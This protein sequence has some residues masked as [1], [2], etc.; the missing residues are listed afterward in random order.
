MGTTENKFGVAFSGGGY[1]ATTYHIGTMRA[2]H[3]LRV[4][5]KID[6]L[7][8][9]SGGSIA[10]AY[11]TLH[12]KN[13]AYPEIE[14]GLLAGLRKNTVARAFLQPRC[15]LGAIYVLGMI[16]LIGFSFAFWH[17]LITSGILVAYILSIVFFQFTIFPISL[18][19]Q[20]AYSWLFFKNKKMGD[21]S[22]RP[23]LVMNATN[24]ETGKLWSFSKRKMDDA[25][26]TNLNP[27]ILFK[28]ENF[29]I[30]VAVS[31]SSC[32]PFAFNPVRIGKKYFVNK[33]DASLVHPYLVD[34]GVYDNQGIH[35][36]IQDPSSYNCKIILVS[37]AGTGVKWKSGQKNV[38]TV[39][40]RMLDILMLRIKNMQMI[41]G[42]FENTNNIQAHREIG[43]FSLSMKPQ[44]T[45][46]F[47]IKLFRKGQL[48]K[49]MIDAQRLEGQENQPDEFLI[50]QVKRNILWSEIEAM[51]PTAEELA[52]AQ[53]VGT[54]LIPLGESKTNALIKHSYC[55]TH[56]FMRLYCP[57]LLN[58]K[59]GFS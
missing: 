22:D 30:S 42:V 7:A 43:Y 31:A 12:A 49:L 4:L 16:V 55:M 45:I 15:L 25:T 23:E 54:N 10:G 51:M 21:L 32:V 19:I 17:P 36:L 38:I 9:N 33:N 59:P 47:F 53:S 48:T 1:R 40:M 26:Y 6:V 52:L 41:A 3:R 46:P 27:P 57:S 29:P 50:T 56:I 35:K 58:T 13:K 28:T 37:D 18:G 8:T 11:Y 39:L 5:D 24:V 44:D 14:K 2:L 20:Q 34:G